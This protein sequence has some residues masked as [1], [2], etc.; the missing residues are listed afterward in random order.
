[1]AQFDVFANPGRNR[2]RIPYV[3]DVQSDLLRDLATRVVV[4]LGV[5]DIVERQYLAAL[6]PVF[7][8]GRRQVVL[9]ST[10]IAHLPARIL[11]RPVA[12]LETNRFEILRAIDAVL[13]GV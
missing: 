5:P 4:P 2:E 9:L 6:H 3:L 12:N 10:E 8:V 1:M 13:S 11:A 7:R